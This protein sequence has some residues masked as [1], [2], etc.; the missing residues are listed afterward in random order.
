MR[1]PVIQS[2]IVRIFGLIFIS[3]FTCKAQFKVVNIDEW[4]R[5]KNDTTYI[6]M[7]NVTSKVNDPYKELFKQ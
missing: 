4:D 2:A 7:D 5:V 6:L 3:A 1:L